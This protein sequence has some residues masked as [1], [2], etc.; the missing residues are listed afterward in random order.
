MIFVRL[1]FNDLFSLFIYSVVSVCNLCNLSPETI[2]N[3]LQI[4]LTFKIKKC[5]STLTPG[6]HYTHRLSTIKHA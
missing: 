2:N 3:F 4:S 6:G 1:R 5:H